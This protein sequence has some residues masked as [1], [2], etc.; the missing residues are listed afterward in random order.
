MHGSMHENGYDGDPSNAARSL[1]LSALPRPPPAPALLV[2]AS[3]I[4][5]PLR[6]HTIRR[7]RPALDSHVA[8]RS[9]TRSERKKRRRPKLTGWGVGRRRQ[10]AGSRVAVARLTKRPSRP[11]PI[12]AWRDA[13]ETGAGRGRSA[14][15]FHSGT[16]SRVACGA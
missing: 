14:D 6:R 13:G 3:S 5:A 8:P 2:R 1:D 16:P 12:P 11:S 9:S 15:S 7:R 10:R 4:T